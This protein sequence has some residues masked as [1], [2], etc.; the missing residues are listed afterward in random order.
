M[1]LGC[2]PYAS[3]MD[4]RKLEFAFQLATMEAAD[5][6]PARVAAASWPRQA[7]KGLPS[8]HAGVA[9]SLERAVGPNV[10]EL[11]LRRVPP[12]QA[13]SGLPVGQ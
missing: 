11:Q 3:W 13:S 10:A 4:Q 2:R 8:M 6:L 1:E 9:A 12:G 5:R 7:R